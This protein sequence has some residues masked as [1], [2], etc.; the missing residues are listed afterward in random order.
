MK[1]LTTLLFA[2]FTLNAFGQGDAP[3]FTQGQSQASKAVSS[4]IKVPH[5]QVTKL[6]SSQALLET[7]NK[8]RLINPGFEHTIYNTGWSGALT[9]TASSSAA[10][11]T[12]ALEG[13]KSLQLTCNGG[14]SGGTCTY[15]QDANTSFA[16]IAETS[17]FL[18]SDESTGAV[19]VMARKNGVNSTDYS[20]TSEGKTVGKYYAYQILGEESGSTSS[21]I[22]IEIT[23]AAS[24]SVTIEADEAK[25][26][27]SEKFSAVVNLSTDTDWASC[28][29][30][31]SDFTGF[32]TVTSIETQ[33][34]RSGGDLL[35]RGKFTVGTPT[36]VEARLA[37]KH[38]GNALT[39][40][41]VSTI[42][43]LQQ[44][45]DAIQ[46][47]SGTTYFRNALLIEP[48]VTYATFGHQSSTLAALSKMNGNVVGAGTVFSI[49]NVSIPING[50]TANSNY[51]T[52]TNDVFSTDTASLFH[53]AT[54][55]LS[56]E[57]GCFNTYSYAINSN[58]KTICATAPTQ[59]IASMNANGIQ[60][61]TR[62]YNAASTCGNPARFELMVGTKYKTSYPINLYKNTGKDISGNLDPLVSSSVS[63][64]GALMRTYSETTGKLVVDVGRRIQGST[65]GA[66]LY[67]E[68]DSNPTT[69]Y[70][71]INDS[72][73]GNLSGINAGEFVKS[74]GSN[75]N[76][77]V[78]SVYFGSGATCSTACTTGTCTICRQTGNKITSVTF[79]STGSFN[80]NG[81]DGTKY[82]CAGSGYNG[83]YMPIFQDLA[84]STSSLARVAMGIGATAT[85]ASYASVTCIGAP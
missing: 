82:S 73:N 64:F 85:N 70:V 80:L 55:C 17:I 3:P 51:I 40:K 50:W 23:V 22:I 63:E 46:N 13:S 71:V 27:V 8:N 24:G 59:T 78:Q 53:K 83:G 44:A 60:I 5:S 21:G 37:L 45:G 1:N 47:G 12:P 62:A 25:V 39:S 15:Y 57:I 6:S 10:A 75:G 66:Y 68:D 79:V 42:A 72:K 56:T 16:T 61:F 67:F 29:H 34:K 9:G 28:G 84:S 14:A 38:N 65:T 77:D 26:A 35:M 81:V 7:G 11:V 33:C 52:T 69:G 18:K 49:N 32:G 48:S 54:A 36:G 30:T 31:T 74:I 43:S 20:V 2:I 76:V 58:T 41:G 19:K 4:V